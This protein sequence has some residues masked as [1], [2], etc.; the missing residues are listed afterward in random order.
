L[1]SADFGFGSDDSP[2]S[3]I[4]EA[5]VAAS[6]GGQ[7]DFSQWDNFIWDAG[8]Q[9][10]AD[11]GLIGIGRNMSMSIVSLGEEDGGHTFYGA[12]IHYSQRRLDR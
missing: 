6:N 10:L 11:V 8:T 12:T 7:W 2:S 5:L 4:N 1:I 9:S 3:L